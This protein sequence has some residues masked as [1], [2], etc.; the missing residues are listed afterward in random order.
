[1]ITSV[2]ATINVK[3][4]GKTAPEEKEVSKNPFEKLNKTYC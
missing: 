2:A 1:M 3:P 4:E